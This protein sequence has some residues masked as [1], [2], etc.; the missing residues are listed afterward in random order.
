MKGKQVV[1]TIDKLML[2][3]NAE[4][5]KIVGDDIVVSVGV[6]SNSSFTYQPTYWSVY[7]TKHDVSVFHEISLDGCDVLAKVQEWQNS[8]NME[9]EKRA[10]K[11]A[12]E[13]HNADCR[14]KEA[15]CE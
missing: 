5:Q 3:L 7:L 10:D 4:I 13:S 6:T 1:Q 15:A 2:E 12:A 8:R 11:E 9:R 14:R